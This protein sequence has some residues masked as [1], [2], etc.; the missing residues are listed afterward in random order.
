MARGKRKKQVA[1]QENTSGDEPV[2]PRRSSMRVNLSYVSNLSDSGNAPSPKRTSTKSDE[3]TS[4]ESTLTNED[5][6]K[7]AKKSKSKKANVDEDEDA[8]TPA[9]AANVTVIQALSPPNGS[10]VSE[11]VQSTSLTV[12]RE[13]EQQLNKTCMR[14]KDAIMNKT[15]ALFDKETE[16]AIKTSEV[17]SPGYKSPVR[18]VREVGKSRSPS[19]K[20][21]IGKNDQIV[22]LG[23]GRKEHPV[24]VNSMLKRPSPEREQAALDINEDSMDCN[25]SIASTPKK[26]RLE[27]S[28][29]EKD[30]SGKSSETLPRIPVARLFAEGNDP[31]NSMSEI[32][33]PQTVISLKGTDAND[34]ASKVNNISNISRL[35]NELNHTISPILSQGT[36]RSR[37]SLKKKLTKTIMQTSRL[38]TNGINE[39]FVNR[40][41]LTSSSFIERQNCNNVEKSNEKEVVKNCMTIDLGEK[42]DTNNGKAINVDESDSSKTLEVENCSSRSSMELTTDS[43]KMPIIRRTFQ[44][45]IRNSLKL[46]NISNTHE[47][48]SFNQSTQKQTSPSVNQSKNAKE[49]TVSELTQKVQ[50]NGCQDDCT[51]NTVRTSLNV[52]TSLDQIISADPVVQKE[53]QIPNNLELT[54]KGCPNHDEE[55]DAM[56]IPRLSTCTVRCSMRVN[57]SLDSV[58]KSSSSK[59]TSNEESEKSDKITV[60]PTD[61]VNREKENNDKVVSRPSTSTIRSS[62][63][64]N[65]SL[66]SVRKSPVMKTV[67]DINKM[68]SMV[69]ETSSTEDQSKASVYT[70]KNQSSGSDSQLENVS[71]MERI[72]NISATKQ[73][74]STEEPNEKSISARKSSKANSTEEPNKKSINARKSSEAQNNRSNATRKSDG[75]ENTSSSDAGVSSEEESNDSSTIRKS[76]DENSKSRRKSSTRIEDTSSKSRKSN[77]ANHTNSSTNESSVV[78]ATPYPTSRSVL[79]RT[80]IKN[81]IAMNTLD[82]RKF[83]DSS[84]DEKE[85]Q[86]PVPK[87]TPN[88]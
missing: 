65:T 73:A 40:I 80:I 32:S 56:V 12:I 1:V 87:K 33:P 9:S 17:L 59:N 7:A 82:P 66:D 85:F 81:N 21:N 26:S 28:D 69:E 43:A 53:N 84:D 54:K 35:S 86:S 22:I 13:K 52:N 39:S 4:E 46:D 14:L 76:G 34:N 71:L 15:Q 44:N 30:S 48:R 74:Q 18:K 2:K 70:S 25:Q 38:S 27:A 57:T 58:R 79:L 63:H 5:H 24:E 10:K 31:N 61:T 55:N 51:V 67:L 75:I 72:R 49:A 42:S 19:V 50:N 78:E 36:R 60:Q 77:G 23:D 62:M 20:V 29:K 11:D 88:K 41:P 47:G 64:V 6:P 68:L 45:I 16:L 83:V 37:L 3:V 8:A